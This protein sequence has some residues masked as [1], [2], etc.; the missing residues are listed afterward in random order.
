ML[1]ALA[2]VVL[3]LLLST[4]GR[5]TL[6]AFPRFTFGLYELDDGLRGRPFGFGFCPGALVRGLSEAS[7]PHLAGGSYGFHQPT[8]KFRVSVSWVGFV[9]TAADPTFTEMGQE[10]NGGAR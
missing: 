2:M 5:E 4:F 3:G 6:T 8:Y 7:P 1:K 9:C 10:G